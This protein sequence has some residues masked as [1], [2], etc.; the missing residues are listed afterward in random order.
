VTIFNLLRFLESSSLEHF[1][2]LFFYFQ[3]IFGA[4]APAVDG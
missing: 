3:G 1:I 4:I 2:I